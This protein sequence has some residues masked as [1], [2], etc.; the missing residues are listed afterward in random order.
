MHLT[1]DANHHAMN[2]LRVSTFARR[3]T[4]L[5]SSALVHPLPLPVAAAPRASN[6]RR[7]SSREGGGGGGR[8]AKTAL[9]LGS[10]GC[11]GSHIVRHLSR[12]LG[13]TVTVWASRV[14]KL[15]F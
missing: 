7:L 4:P 15:R 12:N 3:A 9:V 10:S 1:Y 13:H 14:Q 11:L 8:A 6:K 2:A 5:S